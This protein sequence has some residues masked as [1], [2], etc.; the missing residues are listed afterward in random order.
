MHHKIKSRRSII[1]Y[2]N[3]RAITIPTN[4]AVEDVEVV[5][6]KI[7]DIILI[8]PFSKDKK[9]VLSGDLVNKL[10][11]LI[12]KIEEESEKLRELEVLKSIYKNS[13]DNN[14]ASKIKEL[15]RQLDFF[16]LHDE[17]E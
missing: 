1:L 16:R 10:E 9:M 11:L 17:D 6:R 4:F 13:P 8:T 5:V 2:G 14:L 3:S 15:E 12:K 7:D